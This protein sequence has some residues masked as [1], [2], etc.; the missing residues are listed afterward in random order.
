MILTISKHLYTG[1]FPMPTI[2]I[3]LFDSYNALR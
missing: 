1:P 2:Y 3:I